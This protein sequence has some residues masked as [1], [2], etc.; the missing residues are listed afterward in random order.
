MSLKRIFKDT[1]DSADDPQAFI[2]RIASFDRKTPTEI[3]AAKYYTTNYLPYAVAAFMYIYK[4]AA[5]RLKLEPEFISTFWKRYAAAQ[6]HMQKIAQRYDKTILSSQICLLLKKIINPVGCILDPLQFVLTIQSLAGNP[7]S[8]SL[9][10]NKTN[11][12]KKQQRRQIPHPTKCKF[13]ALNKCRYSH[14][15]LYWQK[16]N[17]NQKKS[18]SN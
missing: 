17:S 1:I 4:Y 15:K 16:V 3:L 9:S 7:L 11:K 10:I 13:C 18:E 12:V 8:I 2:T 14:H 6:S 5:D